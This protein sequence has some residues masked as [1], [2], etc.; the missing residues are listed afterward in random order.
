MWKARVEN[1]RPPPLDKTVGPL[2]IEC[3]SDNVITLEIGQTTPQQTLLATPT[4]T[5]TAAFSNQMTVSDMEGANHREPDDLK[6]NNTA[7]CRI[8]A[9]A[10]AAGS[11][12]IQIEK[13]VGQAEVNAVQQ[14]DL[15]LTV[16]NNGPLPA[17]NIQIKDRHRPLG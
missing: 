14:Q 6:S 4:K 16:T 15:T 9:T 7:S 8:G 11:A 2:A 5:N 17:T 10:T 1:A 12:D 13:S 3:I